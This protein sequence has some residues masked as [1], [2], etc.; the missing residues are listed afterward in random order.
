MQ[1]Y[2]RAAPIAATSFPGPYTLGFFSYWDSLKIERS[3]Q[4][5]LQMSL[6]W[7]IELLPPLQ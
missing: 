2:G 1:M 7:E 4:L 6:S 5:S 3:Y